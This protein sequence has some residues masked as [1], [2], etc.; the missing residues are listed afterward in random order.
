MGYM[1]E[2]ICRYIAENRA[3]TQ[4]YTVFGEFPQKAASMR[5]TEED[6]AAFCVAVCREK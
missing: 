4:Y 6:P 1:R 5:L 2:D 3:L